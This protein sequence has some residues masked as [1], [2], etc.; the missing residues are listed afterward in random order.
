MI[1]TQYLNYH[2]ILVNIFV[3]ILLILVNAKCVLQFWYQYAAGKALR[4]EVLHVMR[5]GN[6]F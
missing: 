6:I 1:H 5:V 4:A 3:N 2:V